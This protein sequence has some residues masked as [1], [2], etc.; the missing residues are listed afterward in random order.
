MPD[1]QRRHVCIV[2]AGVSGLRCAGVLISHGFQVT[3]L[4]ARNR[5]GGRICQSNELGYTID[6]GPNWIHTWDSGE[7]H[8]IWK[9]ATETNTPMHRWNSKQMIFDSSGKML[10]E[11]TTDRLSTLLW[12]IIEE[13]FRFSAEAHIKDSGMSI[14]L[15]D[16]LHD[17]IRRRSIDELPDQR[18]RDTL[19]QMSEMWG[20]YVGE[21]VWKQ[22]LRF[23]WMEECCGGE[24]MFVA[25]SYSAILDRISKPVTDAANILFEKT[26]ISVQMPADRSCG[27]R[28]CVTTND[29]SVWQ[30]DEVVMTT[31]LGWLKKYLDCFS[32][33]LPPRLKSAISNLKLSQLEKYINWLCPRYTDETNPHHWPQEIW[34]LASFSPPNNHPTILFYLY[35][36][37]SRHVVNLI[38]NQSKEGKY[39]ILTKFFFPYYSRLPGF[40]SSDPSCTPTEVLA[41]EW[42][43]DELN[44]YGSYCNFQSGIAEADKDV[45]TIRNGCIEQ[46]LWFCGE[47]TA[48]FEECGTV[49]GA[50]LSGEDIGRRIAELYGPDCQ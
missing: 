3:I 20:A 39:D 35:G 25:S 47:H 10:P 32:P 8:P 2:G 46:R 18:E 17:F 26:V 44:G 31:P 4:E 14:P 23:A 24:E 11:E 50:Y 12:K 28:V 16:S 13:A 22:S 29:G 6:V 5:L 21:P 19:L 9:L 15:E 27:E 1:T 38:Y 37:C 43:K 42:L 41:T 36:D 30:F 40:D 49:A 33:S 48:P 34:N 7:I 45:E